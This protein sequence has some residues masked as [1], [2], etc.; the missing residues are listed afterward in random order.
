MIEIFRI[1]YEKYASIMNETPSSIVQTTLKPETKK[2]E[3]D[4]N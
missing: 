4:L 2:F 1:H 3:R